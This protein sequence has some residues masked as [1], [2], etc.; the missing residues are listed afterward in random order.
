MLASTSLREKGVER[1]VAAAD[2]SYHKAVILGKRRVKDGECAAIWNRRGEVRNVVGPKLVY[3]SF[4][5]GNIGL[6]R[7]G[8]LPP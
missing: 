3:I 6:P 4:S 1:V 5:D 8:G 7:G 2:A